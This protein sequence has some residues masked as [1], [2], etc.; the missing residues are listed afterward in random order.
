MTGE[1]SLSPYSL[2]APTSTTMLESSYSL[3]S[4]VA[5]SRGAPWPIR[6]NAA[7]V[8]KPQTRAAF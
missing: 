7:T 6:A 1:M 5:M 2:L 3:D 8:V 4:S